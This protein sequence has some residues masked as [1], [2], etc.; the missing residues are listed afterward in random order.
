MCDV[1]L[2]GKFLH[3]AGTAVAYSKRE[4]GGTGMAQHDAKF[5]TPAAN[6]YAVDKHQEVKKKT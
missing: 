6:R 1:A 3:T 2:A 4:R 5:K